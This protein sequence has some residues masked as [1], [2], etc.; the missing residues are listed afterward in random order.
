VVLP[1]N[2]FHPFVLVFFSIRHT[3]EQFVVVVGRVSLCASSLF[4]L[5]PHFFHSFFPFSS[6]FLFDWRMM[7][8]MMLVMVVMATP[9]KKEKPVRDGL[10]HHALF[11]LAE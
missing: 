8:D 6:F 9:K 10:P 5:L 7:I 2:R 4:S 11:T 3:S 1:I